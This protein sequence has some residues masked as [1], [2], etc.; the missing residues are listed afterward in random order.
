MSFAQKKTL[1]AIEGF[2]GRRDQYHLFTWNNAKRALIQNG[3]LKILG[4]GKACVQRRSY[5]RL[6]GTV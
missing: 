3:D 6:M 1:E 4:N 2:T 5:G